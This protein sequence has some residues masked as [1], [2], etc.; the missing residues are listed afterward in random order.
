MVTPSDVNP[1]VTPES[2]I[3][4]LPWNKVLG[5]KERRRS[6]G[7]ERSNPSSV[8]KSLQEKSAIKK[9]RKVP[10]TAVVQL[11]SYG[12][13]TNSEVMAVARERVNIRDLNLRDMR[14][15]IA[16]SG[17][18][19]LEIPGPDRQE[20][21]NKL[22]DRLK[23]ALASH[24]GVRVSRPLKTAELRISNIEASV[25]STE[26]I[27]AVSEMGTFDCD[28]IRVGPI[29]RALNGQNT[30]VIRC[31]LSLANKLARL[32]KIQLGW[33]MSRI[34]MLPERALTCF[35]CLE[36]GHTRAE[37]R[38]SVDRSDLCYRCGGLG[39]KV[40]GCHLPIRC[41]V[42]F[43]AGHAH[44]HRLGSLACNP[45]GRKNPS[46]RRYS[47]MAGTAVLAPTP[48][49][50]RDA[51]EGNT[52]TIPVDTGVD[53]VVDTSSTL[54]VSMEVE[55]PTPPEGLKGKETLPLGM[56]S[57]TVNIVPLE[58]QQQP[59]PQRQDAQTRKSN[60]SASPEY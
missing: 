18:L 60:I 44:N 5:R 41:P 37:C 24:E 12:N 40:Q 4:E 1:S 56:M 23:E 52:P 59:L 32:K 31:P 36:R 29:N 13:L 16:R 42:C 55:A 7:K 11:L 22:A 43:D 21:A 8:V 51:D 27:R 50:V 34:N 58:L 38:S 20:L 33:T 57:P 3:G 17:A 25:T 30:T 48:M 28:T 54:Y 15:R 14:S 35:R 9:L 49:E 10:N 46:G 39:H 53:T 26:I 6:E 2:T 19:L 47:S 45:R